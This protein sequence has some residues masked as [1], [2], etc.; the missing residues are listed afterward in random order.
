MKKIVCLVG[1]MILFSFGL[2]SVQAQNYDRLWKEV[3]GLQ[4][5]DLPRSVID[6]VDRIYALARK[7]ENRPQMMKAVSIEK[8]SPRSY[9]IISSL[10]STL[11]SLI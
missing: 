4:E 10:V 7:E 2:T 6:A 3:E 5:K 11:T 1:L 9:L 8:S